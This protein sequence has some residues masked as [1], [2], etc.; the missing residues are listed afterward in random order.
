[1]MMMRTDIPGSKNVKEL[2]ETQRSAK[3]GRGGRI[4]KPREDR[5]D[6]LLEGKYALWVKTCE[7]H[8]AG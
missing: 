3:R 7:T 1:M 6:Q 2:P 5:S 8:K 4:Q